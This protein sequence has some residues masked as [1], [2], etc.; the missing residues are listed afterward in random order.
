[1]NDLTLRYPDMPLRTVQ[2]ERTADAPRVY[3]P[4]TTTRPPTFDWDALT[5]TCKGCEVKSGK[6]NAHTGLCPVCD[7]PIAD[8]APPRPKPAPRP[9][10]PRRPRAPRPSTGRPVGRPPTP[11]DHEAVVEAYTG[12]QAIIDIAAALRVDRSRVRTALVDAGVELRENRG[13]HFLRNIDDNAVLA[14]YRAGATKAHLAERYGVTVKTIRRLLASAGV[15]IRDDRAVASGSKPIE[16]DPQLV[17]QVRELYL[18]RRLSQSQVAAEL[19][20]TVKVVAGVMARH[21]IPGRKGETGHMDG[22]KGL[23]QEMVDLGLTAREIKAWAAEQGLIELPMV[24]I[25]SRRVFDAY[26]EAHHLQERAS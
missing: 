6:V 23:R 3:R 22:S 20:T 18:D 8:V 2:Q 15:T 1:M 13:R 9:R 17:D 11:I 5:P 24:G 26:V 10:T 12:G 4:H 14:D 16:Y 7:P 21:Q 25:P 19:G